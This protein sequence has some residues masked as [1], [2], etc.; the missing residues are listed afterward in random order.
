MREYVAAP[1][2]LRVPDEDQI[3]DLIERALT[4]LT[5]VAKRACN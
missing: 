3:A 2:R 1:P 4:L 5:R